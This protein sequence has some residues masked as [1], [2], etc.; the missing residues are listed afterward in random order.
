MCKVL[1]KL[2]ALQANQRYI[3]SKLVE[4]KPE[5]ERGGEGREGREEEGERERCQ[6]LDYAMEKVWCLFNTQ[7]FVV[8]PEAEQKTTNE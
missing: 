4:T 1:S 7:L 2:P 5:R 3:A 8:F 6:S